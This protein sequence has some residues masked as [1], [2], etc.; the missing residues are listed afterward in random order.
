[1]SAPISPA[2]VGSL[3]LG[4]KGIGRIFTGNYDVLVEG[5]PCA[6]TGSLVTPYPP[7]NSVSNIITGTYSVLVGGKPMASGE[8]INSF[9]DSVDNL[10][11]ALNV[12]V[13]L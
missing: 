6:T 8:S 13:G 9:G 12:E 3:V 7:E 5:K 11:C 4:K 1:M 2:V 10:T